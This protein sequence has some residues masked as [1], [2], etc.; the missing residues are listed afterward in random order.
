WSGNKKISDGS[1]IDPKTS[2]SPALAVFRGKLYLA[3]RGE[4]KTDIYVSTFDG[5][6]W[7]GNKKIS[8]GSSID[9]ETKTGVALVATNDQLLML[10]RGEDK[11]DLY[12]AAFDGETWS[13]NTRISQMSSIDPETSTVPAAA[14]LNG[15]L[16]VVYRGKDHSDI[17]LS[18]LTEQSFR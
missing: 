17:Y 11:A 16:N 1:S 6:T 10:Y 4:D 3:Y 9:P 13:G 14:V 7:S 5:R 12:V 2:T 15:T 8:D 18:K